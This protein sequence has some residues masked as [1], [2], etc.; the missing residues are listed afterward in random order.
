MLNLFEETYKTYF[1]FLSFLN[2]DTEHIADLVVNYGISIVHH[3]TSNVIDT[4]PVEHRKEHI[5][6]T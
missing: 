2:T 3:Y 1:R 4:H 5:Y 6:P